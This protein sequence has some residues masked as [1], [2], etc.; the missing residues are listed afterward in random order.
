M[1]QNT[2]EKE[3]K[4][5]YIFPIATT[6]LTPCKLVYTQLYIYFFFCMQATFRKR[7]N[8]DQSNNNQQKEEDICNILSVRSQN[9]YVWLA[10]QSE[11]YTLCY[12]KKKKF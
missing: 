11:I 9:F 6:S 1:K 4:G 12:L 2:K 10:T 5:K 3:N 7:A 8:I